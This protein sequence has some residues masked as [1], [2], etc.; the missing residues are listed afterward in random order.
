[1]ITNTD[2]RELLTLD[3]VD[4]GELFRQSVEIQK[5]CRDFSVSN[6]T[7]KN[8]RYDGDSCRLLYQPDGADESSRSKAMTRHSLGQLCSKIGV[9]IRYIDKC[10]DSGRLDLASEN[11]NSWI[12]DF[13]KNLFIREYK[14]SIRGVLSDRYSTLDTPHIMEVIDDVLDFNEYRIKGYMLTPE[15]FHARIVQREMM[16]I[17]GEDLFAGIQIDSSDV[18]RSILVVKFMIW[19]QVCTN[20]LCISKGGGVLFQQKHIGIDA[21]DFRN[22]FRES[23]ENIPLLVEHSKYLVEE[24]R[25]DNNGYSIKTFTEQQFKDFVDRIKMKT[26]LS[27]EG[28]NK[29]I[30]FMSA[31]YDYSKWG[32]INSL[33]EVAQDYTL[34]RRLEI[35]KIAGDFLMSA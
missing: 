33:T 29:V 8:V 31:K 11:I 15:R 20:G 23:L 22:D 17:N 10:I 32:L 6:A 2:T 3:R 14:D 5:E 27:D 28:V 21:M 12:D 34:E 25:K 19:K 24:A 16:N 30:D 35:E 26:K 18:G 13:G 4:L 9:P 1:M 7:Y